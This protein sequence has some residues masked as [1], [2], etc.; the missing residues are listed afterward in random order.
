MPNFWEHPHRMAVSDN[1]HMM[2]VW[3]N[4]IDSER[5]IFYARYDGV[6]WSDT[7]DLTPSGRDAQASYWDRNFGNLDVAAG[8]DGSFVVAWLDENN[9]GVDAR[10]NVPQ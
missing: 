7:G 1:G 9:S 8:D 4:N 6:D 5:H 2:L 3:V 10:L